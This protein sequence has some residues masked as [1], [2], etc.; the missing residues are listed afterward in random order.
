MARKRPG[1]R[2]VRPRSE[3]AV[4]IATAQPSLDLAEHD[5]ARHRVVGQERLVEEHL[6]EALVAVEP[7]EAAHG[8]ARRVERHEQV[9]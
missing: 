6:G 3:P 7:A 8:H 4:A 5:A 9:A 2:S 1:E